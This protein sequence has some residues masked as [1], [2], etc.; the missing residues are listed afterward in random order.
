MKIDAIS[1]TEPE[2]PNITLTITEP[3]PEQPKSKKKP[4]VLVD[5]DEVPVYDEKKDTFG[6]REK[7]LKS[8][9]GI[10]L[11]D[12]LEKQ[13]GYQAKGGATLSEL[14][15]EIMLIEAGLPPQISKPISKSGS[16]ILSGGNKWTDFVKDYAKSYNTTYGCALSDVGIKSAYKLFKDGKTWYFPKV[17]ASIETQTDDFIEPTP[18]EA[19]VNIE[20]VVSRI[21]EKVRELEALGAKKGAVSY[22]SKTIITDL[23]FVNMLKK[24][25]GKCVVINIMKTRGVEVGINVNSNKDES[26]IRFPVYY[27]RL[28]EALRDCIQ[29]GIKVIAVPLSLNFGKRSAGHANM[30]IYRPFKRIVERFE[31]HGRAYGNSMVDNKSFNDQLKKLWET[32]LTPFL[33]KVRYVEPDQLCPD[34]RGFQTLEGQLKGL[35]SE[36]EGFCSMWS[37]FLAEM[38][39]INPDK[40]TKEIIDEVF[41][42]TK[43]DPAYLKSL[44]RGYVVDIEKGL[45][46]LLKIMGKKGFSFAGKGIN[47]PYMTIAGIVPEWEKWLLS[48]AFDSKSYSEAPPQ[49][50]PLP[51]V[52]LSQD[53]KQRLKEEYFKKVAGWTMKVLKDVY[54]LYGMKSN[55]PK[56]LDTAWFLIESLAEGDWV[57][58]G[59]TGLEDIDVILKEGLWLRG[60]D[61]KVNLA[62]TGYFLNKKLER[63]KTGSGVG[64][65]GKI[66]IGKSLSKA[67]DPKKNGVSKAFE[68]VSKSFDKAGKSMSEGMYQASQGLNKINPMMIALNDKKTSKLMRQSG[69]IT[70]DYLLPAVVAMGK[71]VYDATA[72]TASTMITGNPIAGKILADALWDNMVANKGID[73]RDRQK[74]EL[75]GIVSSQIGNVL[76]KASGNIGK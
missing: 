53:D 26:D 56:R 75:L 36:G 17:S 63:E 62:Q 14:A 5:D 37:F 71:P 34:V 68:P 64:S 6:N 59:A 39:F 72:M 54:A 48:V 40:S 9:S 16:G 45:D 61:W 35:P 76:G 13:H 57:D 15:T 19:P 25:G 74:S 47:S 4:V 27:N 10:K 33:G 31:P 11:R 69:E 44:I 29:R 52:V 38:T 65:G 55:T 43:K 2:Q 60:K 58:E 18:T 1:G 24:Y 41:D 23:G 42:I 66:N 8:F 7:L 28:G 22:D 32:D 50:E 67:F 51:D 3:E 20:P 73:P 12:F 70:N 21:E 49:F 30:L 46:G